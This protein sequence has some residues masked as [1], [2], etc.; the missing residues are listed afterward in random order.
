MARAGVPVLRGETVDGDG[1]ESAMRPR[2]RIGYP[3]LV[4]AAFGGGG[5]GMRVVRD[6]G[7]LDDAVGGG[8]AR[9][10]VRVRRRHRLPRALGGGAAP[11]RGADP[12]R[13]P[14]HR[15]PP[16]RARVL[17]PAP[18][19]E[20]RRGVAV[21]RGRRRAARARS[22]PP[23]SPP[24][25]RSATSAPGTVEFLLDADG[26]VPLPRGEHPPPGRAPG[27]RD[28][29]RA[30]PRPPPAARRPGRAAARTRCS[31]R[32]QR[33]HAIE[34]RLYAEDVAAG[35]LPA[36][37]TLHR[38]R[39]PELAG[40][41]RRQ[42][43][44]G[45]LGRR[46]PLRPDARQGHRL[47]ADP[48]RGGAAARR[49]AR[50]RRG[51]RGH[52]Q[53]RPARRHP[54]RARLPR[55]A[56][57]HRVPRAPRPRR[58]G[59]PPAAGAALRVHAIAAALA[60]ARRGAPHAA[61]L[62]TLPS[63]WRNN[64][65]AL[66]EMA[67]DCNDTRIAVG[68]GSGD[69]LAVTVDGEP[70]DGVRVHHVD[71]GGVDLQ[72]D[73]VRR[74][75]RVHAAGGAVHV[76][77]PWARH[78]S[79][80]SSGSPSRGRR[81]RSR[82]ALRADAG[83]RGAGSRRA[84]RH[85]DRGPAAG[86]PGGDEDGAQRAG[87]A[88]RAWSPRCG[89]TSAPRSTPARCSPSWRRRR[90]PSPAGGADRQLLGL[91]RRPPRRRAGDGRGRSDRRPLRGLPRRADDAHPLEGARAH[92]RGLRDDLPQADGAGPR[93]LPRPRHQGGEQRR[94]P[95]PRGAGRRAAGPRRR[96]SGCIRGSPT[97][98]ATTC[99]LASASSAPRG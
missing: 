59:A 49:R 3:V 75:V 6:P 9:G 66:Q 87:A 18:A 86:D 60:G 48:A 72:V 54:P 22:A 56:H 57:R 89:C 25:R 42:R 51:P 16:L 77:S 55:R 39:I 80:R 70:L 65:S 10:G 37:G 83:E 43:R 79:T 81:R 62:G 69:P 44:R 45:R 19:P 84:R 97:S 20:D 95:R 21:D 26:G 50:R 23:R 52:H 73:G 74:R 5:R 88:R 13:Q 17:D 4:K 14:R 33:G 15:G 35:F 24:R 71:E 94:R 2:E 29:H 99:S 31:R 32:G 11:R 90:E 67:Y 38:F 12:R 27:H 28:G 34:V 53:P 82:V 93:H 1:P 91:L 46:H 7:E 63:G 64:P 61:A 41:A 30:R 92:R 78:C 68:Y 36:T 40:G 85:G 47:G 8:P 96:S 98:R 76:D 58:L